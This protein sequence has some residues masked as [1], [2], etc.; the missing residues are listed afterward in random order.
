MWFDFVFDLM[1]GDFALSFRTSNNDFGLW[2]NIYSFGDFPAYQSNLMFFLVIDRQCWCSP[3]WLADASPQCAWH[4]TVA[5]EFILPFLSQF[6]IIGPEDL[7][8]RCSMILLSYMT[9]SDA[10]ESDMNSALVV[11]GSTRWLFSCTPR[12]VVEDKGIAGGWP[13]ADRLVSHLLQ[14]VAK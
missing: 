11:D 13:L 8:G 5:A 2:R 9:S 6:N 10:A 4:I 3:G 7:A 14:E 1:F 12:N